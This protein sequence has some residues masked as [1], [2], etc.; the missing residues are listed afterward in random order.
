MLDALSGEQGCMG[1]E[2]QGPFLQPCGAKPPP[3]P[4][5]CHCQTHVLASPPHAD[6]GQG[7][8]CDVGR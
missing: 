7:P 2:R 1:W 8:V 5:V 3:F 6:L 4:G